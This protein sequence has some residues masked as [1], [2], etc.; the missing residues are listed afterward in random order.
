[1]GHLDSGEIAPVPLAKQSKTVTFQLLSSRRFVKCRPTKP[2]PP[3]IKTLVNAI[4]IKK[5]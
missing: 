2:A 1:M 5:Q 4:P 3:V